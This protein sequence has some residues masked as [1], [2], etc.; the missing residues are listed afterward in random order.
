MVNTNGN[1]DIGKDVNPSSPGSPSGAPLAG[2]CSG[3]GDHKNSEKKH[4]SNIGVILFSVI[5]GVFVVCL[6]GLLVF[7]IYKKTPLFH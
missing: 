1:P 5:G 3:N 2:I 7:Y 4:S 6:I